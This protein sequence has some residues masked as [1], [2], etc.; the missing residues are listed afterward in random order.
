MN[1]VASVQDSQSDFLEKL[2]EENKQMEAEIQ[3]LSATKDAFPAMNASSAS[4]SPATRNS[5]GGT[6]PHSDADDALAFND[7]SAFTTPVCFAVNADQIPRP[8]VCSFI[9]RSDEL[10]SDMKIE[11]NITSPTI[12]TCVGFLVD[13]KVEVTERP[14]PNRVPGRL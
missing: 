12:S 3:R 9:E 8:Q 5:T 1:S 14:M 10:T 2:K 13:N 6:F 4:V 11:T 7:L